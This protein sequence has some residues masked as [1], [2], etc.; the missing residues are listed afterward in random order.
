[1]HLD[2]CVQCSAVR[3]MYKPRCYFLR[4]NALPIKFA[5]FGIANPTATANSA[6]ETSKTATKHLSTAIQGQ[7]RMDTREHHLS[8]TRAR[9]AHR[10]SRKRENTAAFNTVLQ[11]FPE[12]KQRVLRRAADHPIGSWLSVLPCAKN[13]AVLSPRE[14]RD[15]IALRYQKPLMQ[16]P[17]LCDGCGSRFSVDHGLNCPNGGNLIER[18]NEIRDLAGQL[19]SLAFSHVTREP[20]VREPGTG[21]SSECGLVCD[22][23]VRGAWQPQTE[24]LID[25]R[26][27]NTDAQSYA[28]R[29]VMA[30]L[31]SIAKSKK[32]KHRQACWE[33]RADFTPFVIS[34]DGIVQRE[35]EHFLKRLASRLADKWTKSY[36]DTMRFIRTQFSIAVLRATDHCIRGARR[37]M[38]PLHCEDG[39]AMPLF[40]V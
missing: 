6:F 21:D 1:M 3:E 40:S 13:N 39:A 17:S 8:V 7:A 32:A 19:A 34:T 33:R 31:D 10:A 37:K 26:V 35:G 25:F 9:S 24:A 4:V 15:G 20:V 27:C 23:A 22:L 11:T 16:L 18:H 5:G 36:S 28:N 2:Y 30:V 38:Q 29:P 14:F 12:S